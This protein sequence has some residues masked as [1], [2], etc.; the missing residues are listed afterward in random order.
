MFTETKERK[1]NETFNT[2]YNNECAE[3]NSADSKEP[4]DY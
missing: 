2:F 3:C 4:C 1:K